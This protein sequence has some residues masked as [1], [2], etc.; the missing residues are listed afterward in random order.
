MTQFTGDTGLLYN[1]PVINFKKPCV[2]CLVT[3]LVAGLEFMDG[4]NADTDNGLWLHHMVMFNEGPGRWDATCRDNP[5][6]L[7]H[8]GVMTNPKKAERMFASGN[9]RTQFDTT[10]NG[11]VKAGYYLS[12]Q[13]KMHMVIDLMNLNDAPQQVYVTLTFE[14][15]KDTTGFSGVKPVWLDADNCK[16]SDVP[17]PANEKVF[18]VSSKPWKA[19]FAGTILGIGAHLHDGGVNAEITWNNKVT[20]DSEAVYEKGAMP[21][22]KV[23][24]D[25]V[26][27]G[28]EEH[29]AQ[30]G[31]CINNKEMKEGDVFVVNGH[32]DLVKHPGM[33][34]VNGKMS[35]VMA[36][37]VFYVMVPLNKNA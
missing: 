25:G 18:T 19:N 14:T 36:I 29:I 1:Q 33:E 2:D 11:T 10:L 21:D 7:P 20:C 13:D 5:M 32:Y 27:P 30:M 6:S 8:I 23:K 31:Y 34:N 26:A 37:S 24:R 17:V 3:S 9:E 22:R 15:L 28:M 35:M 12:A 16:M 4:K